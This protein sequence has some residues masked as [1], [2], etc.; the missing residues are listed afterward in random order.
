MYVIFEKLLRKIF[1]DKRHIGITLFP[2]SQCDT[3]CSHCIDNSDCKNPTHFTKELAE[4]IVKETRKE[5]WMLSALLTGGGE[6]LMTPEL[7]GIAD[8]FGNYE[9]LFTFGIITSGFTNNETHRKEQFETLL[10][11]HYAKRMMIDQSFSLYHKSFPERLANTMRLIMSIRKKSHFRI[12]AC[13]SLDNFIETQKEIDD[14]VKNLTKEIEATSYALPL[15]WQ[16]SDRRLFH[17][18]ESKLI[19]DSTAYKLHV[20]AFLTPQWHVIK[21]KDG[22]IIMNAQP[23]SLTSEGRGSSVKQSSY[24]YCVCDALRGYRQDTYLIVGP[25]G[26]VYPECSCFPFEHMRLG[27]IGE[28]SLVELVHRKDVFTERIMKAI[29]ADNRMCKWGTEELC[30]LCKKIVAEKGIGLQ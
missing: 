13:M 7:I 1:K 28:D 3:G 11:R 20:E 30:M 6:P 8:A 25:D 10:K 17:Y 15:G 2:T 24:G 16:E 22:G 26:S 12:R 29:L 14:V 18:F 5:R 19:G 4:T 23:I 21:T 9:R 27:K